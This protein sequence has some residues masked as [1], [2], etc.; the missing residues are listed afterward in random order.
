MIGQENYGFYGEV[1]VSTSAKSL[2]CIDTLMFK[3][4]HSIKKMH[5]LRNLTT[6]IQNPEAVYQG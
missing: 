1:P 6:F 2:Y 4:F 3:S 5:C